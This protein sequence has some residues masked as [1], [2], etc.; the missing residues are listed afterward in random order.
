MVFAM[1]NAAGYQVRVW[2]ELLA[3]LDGRSLE[4][5]ETEETETTTKKKSTS[6]KKKAVAEVETQEEVVEN[7]DMFGDESLSDEPTVEDVRK[8]VKTFSAKHG[9][10]KALKLLGKFK[11]TAIPDLKKSDY[12]PLIDF[13]NK[14]LG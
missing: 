6:T 5:K 4:T 13:A 10:D 9:K 12:Q 7:D 2:E 3:E 8:I 11:V 14:H 1:M